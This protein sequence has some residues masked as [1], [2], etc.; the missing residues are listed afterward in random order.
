MSWIEGKEIMVL[1][2][3]APLKN[4]EPKLEYRI[5]NRFFSLPPHLREMTGAGE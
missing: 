3:G 5:A 2:N 4:D 1:P